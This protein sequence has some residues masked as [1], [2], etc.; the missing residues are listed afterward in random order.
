MSVAGTYG[1]MIVNINGATWS[2]SADGP[3]SP[4]AYHYAKTVG[5]PKASDPFINDIIGSTPETFPILY[6]A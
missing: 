3:Y 1:D 5:V 4:F 6:D 2:A